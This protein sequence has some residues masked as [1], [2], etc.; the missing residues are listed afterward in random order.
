VEKTVVGKQVERSSKINSLYEALGRKQDN[1]RKRE[2]REREIEDVMV[3]AMS[4]KLQEEKECINILF[5]NLFLKK[6]LK[7]KMEKLIKEN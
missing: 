1:I 5:S 7:A 2:E 3:R 6:F 4:E